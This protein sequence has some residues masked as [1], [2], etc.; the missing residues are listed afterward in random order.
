MKFEMS[1]V[2]DNMTDLLGAGQNLPVWLAPAF[3]VKDFDADT[4]VAD[5]RR[6]VGQCSQSSVSGF[7]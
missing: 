6:Y 1:A 7:I 5:L 2:A 3:N 4:C